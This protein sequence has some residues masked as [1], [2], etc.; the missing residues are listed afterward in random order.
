ME[1]S[2]P[3][4]PLL[5]PWNSPS[6]TRGLTAIQGDIKKFW[7]RNRGLRISRWGFFLPESLTTTTLLIGP[8]R[9]LDNPKRLQ[10]L[11]GKG[12][13]TSNPRNTQAVPF[14]IT[15]ITLP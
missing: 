13:P 8:K 7:N 12:V 3:F 2:L 5:S 4:L 14:P 15:L 6:Q 10:Q 11:G 1:L 9:R